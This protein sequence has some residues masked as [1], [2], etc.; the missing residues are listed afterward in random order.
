MSSTDCCGVM[1]GTHGWPS[2]RSPIIGHIAATTAT[3]RHARN[4]FRASIAGCEVWTP[5]CPPFVGSPGRCRP[6]PMMM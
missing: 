4:T 1:R 2:G 5:L 3:D 6:Y